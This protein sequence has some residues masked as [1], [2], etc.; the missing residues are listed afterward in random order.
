MWIS[1]K[2]ELYKRRSNS[3]SNN[4]IGSRYWA[5]INNREDGE[6]RK[7]GVQ[8]VFIYWEMWGKQPVAAIIAMVPWPAPWI[9][10]TAIEYLHS[11]ELSSCWSVCLHAH[12]QRWLQCRVA[13]GGVC[14][15]PGCVVSLPFVSV[16]SCVFVFLRFG[17]LL[18]VSCPWALSVHRTVFQTGLAYLGVS[19]PFC[20]CCQLHTD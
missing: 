4:E 3:S 12:V 13:S 19:Q 17:W 18:F 8:G 6:T 14:A 5:G 20:V 9:W 7:L 2:G 15:P 1:G 11:M 16:Q 10:G